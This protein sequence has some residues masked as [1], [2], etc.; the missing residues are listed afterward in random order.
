MRPTVSRPPAEDL[1]PGTTD[2]EPVVDVLS[3]GGVPVLSG[4]GISTESGIPDYRG[5]GGSLSRHTPMTYQDFT[6]GAR[7]RRLL[8]AL[9]E[10]LVR[11]PAPRLHRLHRVWGVLDPGAEVD[12][13]EP[14][15]LA[16]RLD[17]R[18]SYPSLA[19]V[20]CSPNRTLPELACPVA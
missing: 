5:E 7:A 6:A 14:R 19:V 16:Q 18:P 3:T 8:R 15:V 10:R 12:P 2:L 4:S 17:E 1:P 20:T 11:H 13:A 9:H